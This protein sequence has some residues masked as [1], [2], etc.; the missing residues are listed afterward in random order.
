[1]YEMLAQHSFLVNNVLG[2]NFGWE[3]NQVT[4]NGSNFMRSRM[5]LLFLIVFALSAPLL[6]NSSG[7]SVVAAVD[8]ECNPVGSS[9]V[10]ID[11]KPG[12][13]L[14]GYTICTV[15]NPTVH[16]EKIT[17][18]VQADGLSVAAPGSITVAAGG[19]EEFQVN[20]RAESRMSTQARTLT[21]T[22]TVQ[23]ISGLPP[24]NIAESTSNNIINIVQFAEFNVE[25]RS[26]IVE[27]RTGN[28]YELEFRLFNTG[29]GMDK[30]NVRLDYTPISGADFSLPLSKIQVDSMPTP[31]LFRVTVYSPN[32]GSDW[33]LDSS[34]RHILEMNVDVV[35]ESELGCQNG[36]CLT[37]TMN[38]KVIFFQNESA[39]GSS[40]SD[41]ISNVMDY[42]IVLF[43]G[44]GIVVLVPIILIVTLRK[45]N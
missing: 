2:D 1:M 45:K 22:A 18:D 21:V 28:N 13:T 29:N 39:L 44:I 15:S 24:P 32:D 19:E 3:Y 37:T 40:T 14:T 6:E 35:I 30:F 17:I 10:D 11:V 34:G 33:P 16:V 27:L 38:Q 12:S 36:N 8:L 43:G 9:S 42:K 7:Q 23:E 31:E 20:V 41:F 25:M 4:D 5:I 26:P